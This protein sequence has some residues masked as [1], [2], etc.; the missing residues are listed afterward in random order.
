MSPPTLPEQEWLLTAAHR[1]L[2]LYYH[3]F[4]TRHQRMSAQPKHFVDAFM[5]SL[6]QRHVHA[7]TDTGY[8]LIHILVEERIPLRILMDRWINED[9]EVRLR[10]LMAAHDWPIG[11]LVN[12][13]APKPQL[14]RLLLNPLP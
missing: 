10:R 6:P 5:V 11:L 12:F 14:R 2:A 13:G 3:L 4:F 9:E 7:T 8:P 1:T